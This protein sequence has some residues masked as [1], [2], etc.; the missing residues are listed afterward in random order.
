MAKTNDKDFRRVVPCDVFFFRIFQAVSM[1]W[2][3]K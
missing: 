3:T 1:G 2:W